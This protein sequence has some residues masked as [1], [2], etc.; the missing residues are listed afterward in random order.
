MDN[1]QDGAEYLE[2]LS[3]NLVKLE[4]IQTLGEELQM[5]TRLSK[6]DRGARTNARIE[7]AQKKEPFD[8][9]ETSE[10][11]LDDVDN[12]MTNELFNRIVEDIFGK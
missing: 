3:S 4:N 8:E 5:G 12:D 10:D 11:E 7:A 6:T 9:S 2:E 1:N